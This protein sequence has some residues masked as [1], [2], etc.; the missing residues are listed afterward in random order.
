M[1]RER[2]RKEEWRRKGRGEGR[3]EEKEGWRLILYRERVEH[4]G[5]NGGIGYIIYITIIPIR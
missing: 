1:V 2:E 5:K 3:G 4:G